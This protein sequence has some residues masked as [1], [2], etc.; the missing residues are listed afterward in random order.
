MCGIWG[1]LQPR[2]N[3]LE[4]GRAM[5]A[6]IAHRGPDDDGIEVTPLAIL[7]HRRLSIVDLTSCGAQPMWDATRSV[8]IVF[9]GEIY[10]FARLRDELRAD[11]FSFRSTSDTEVILNAY[12][13]WGESAFARLNGIFAFC[14]FDT[15]SGES[16]LVRDPMG[17]KPLFY[18]RTPRGL[19]FA[20]ELQVLLASGLFAAEVDR[21]ALQAYVQLDF[22]PSPMSM[23]RR[24]EKLTGGQLLHVR[25]D[26][27]VSLRTYSN[28]QRESTA[29]QATPAEDLA[30][31]RPL[32]RAAVERQLVAD[33]PV[34]V[35][36]SGGIDSSLVAQVATDIAGSMRTFSIAFDDPSFDERPYFDAVAASIGSQQHT[37]TLRAADMLHL[38]PDVASITGEPLADGSILPTILLSRFTR[39]SV[40][41]ALSGDGAD[42]LFAGYPTHAVSR[43]GTAIGSVPRMQRLLERSA[44]ALLPVSHRNLS[45]DFKIKKLLA[46]ASADPLLQNQRWLGSFDAAAARALLTHFDA[47]AQLQLEQL[48]HAASGH[49][50]PLE[51]L[52]HS[53]QRFYLQDGVLVKVDRASMRSALEVRVPFLDHEVVRFANGL[54]ADRK[55][56]RSWRG[57]RSKAILRDWARELFPPSISERRKK[58]FGVP[59]AKWFSG[60]LRGFVLETLAPA[61]ITRA[62]FFDPAVVTRIVDEHMSRRRDHRKQIF[63]L[64]TFTMWYEQLTR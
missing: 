43:F 27:S 16:F 62:G 44:H 23:V 31:F 53:D 30:A 48:L 22:V 40:K 2:E 25:G 49:G 33:V 63:N 7:G 11:G 13:R 46:G 5:H 28:L 6:A 26:G 36:L 19:A 3:P 24:I 55:L 10:D 42:E 38:L 41:V 32:F 4:A 8:C 60:E 52:L 59:L 64:L 34:G 21:A 1:I 14:L 35:F 56:R 9:N 18:G 39:E 12:L 58:G 37:A 54:P 51:E 45:T 15:R 17:I 20:S 29:A 61:R 50:T 57:T 47:D